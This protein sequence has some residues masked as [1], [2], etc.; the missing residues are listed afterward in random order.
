MRIPTELLNRVTAEDCIDGLKKIPDKSIDLIVCDPP[1]FKTI[2]E[3]WDY[4]WR[5]EEDYLS[6][7][8]N[9]LKELGRIAKLSAS[10]YLFGYFKI[11]AQMMPLVTENNF[12]FRQQIVIDKGLRAISGRAT[13]GYQ[14]FPTVTESILF[15]VQDSKP[16]IK[17][18]LKQKQEEAGLSAKEINEKL[19]AASIGGGLW[20]LY[21]GENILAQVPTE[22]NW[23]K[24]QKILN[25]KKD[26]SDI[27]F[28][29]NKE[30]GLTDVW[31][32]IDF[33]EEER[34]H[35]TQK[36]LKL[37][38][39]LILTSSTEGAIVLD[40]FSGCG[41][42]AL[43]CKKLK[44]RFVGFEIDKKYARIANRRLESMLY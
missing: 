26:Y 41:T 12:L 18:F 25:F 29:F 15:F 2:N 23:E 42:T 8:K 20:S 32:D 9:W 24:L 16:T 22:E 6:W 40:P 10:F 35:P 4:Q 28:T 36:P 43:A 27:K 3:T 14:M 13:K 33:Y 30:M 21:T 39:R 17:A 7:T 31:R 5:T 37:I 38:G 11:L 1:Y 34:Y 44:R 19:D